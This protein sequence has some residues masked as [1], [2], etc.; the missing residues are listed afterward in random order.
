[1]LHVMLQVTL[2]SPPPPLPQLLHCMLH[3]IRHMPHS[4]GSLVRRAV[5][6]CTRLARLRRVQV[7]AQRRLVHREG[8][9]ELR[10]RDL[11]APMAG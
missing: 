6:C 11:R 8:R 3:R 1:M 9:R 4:V 10:S 5:A 7:A 2:P